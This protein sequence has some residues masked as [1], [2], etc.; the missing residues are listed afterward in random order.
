MFYRLAAIVFISLSHS[1]YGQSIDS[2]VSS[3]SSVDEQVK[4]REQKLDSLITDGEQKLDSIQDFAAGQYAS[5]KSSYDS[6]LQ[7]GNFAVQKVNQKIDSLTTLNLP[8]NKLTQKLDSIDRWKSEKLNAINSKVEKLKSDV[9][10][11][12]TDLELPPE[13]Q[14]KTAELTSA[15]SKLE[16]S[17]PVKDLPLSFQDKLNLPGQLNGLELPGISNPL[18]GQSLGV[19]DV[20]IPGVT[21]QLSN[22]ELPTLSDVEIPNVD[23]DA[24]NETTGKLQEYQGQLS[25]VP[26]N[27]EDAGKMAETEATK[28]TAV[29]EVQNELGE[30]SELTGMAG[31][32]KDQDALKQQMKQE[33][34]KQAVNHFAG[35]EEQLQKAMETMSKYKQKYSS[36]QSL[37]DIPEKRPNEMRGKPLIERLVPG[38]GLQIFIKDDWMVDF[39]PYVGYRFNT[40]L[41]IGAGWNYRLAYNHD[42][43]QF[44]QDARVYGP[45]SYG[46]FK[47]GKGFSGHLQV[48]YMNTF[49]P[50]QFSS[51]NK[52]DEG[53]EWVFT[54][55][56][57]MKKEY[58]FI[59]NVKGTVYVLYNLYDPH[60]RSPYGDKLNMRIG[61][62][63]PMKKKHKDALKNK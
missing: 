3:I 35:K 33:V 30:V 28:I 10:Q 24:L 44:N 25:Q 52:D 18:A 7:K 54:T 23:M 20:E 37:S 19:P 21:D 31:T 42:N 61:F 59:K 6:V 41:T 47:I 51:G 45:R 8:T 29:G 5:L 22:V 9:Q 57:G 32:L 16:A 1:L 60:H 63:F 39:N 27:L 46:E 36:L 26:T 38:V 2:L 40:R 62:E 53:R 15:V 12:I 14:E 55:M 58:R 13:L 34:Q 48:E 43:N 56:A 17:L 49:V 4:V 50:P 11:K